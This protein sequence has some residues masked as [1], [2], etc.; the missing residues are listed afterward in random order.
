MS[1]RKQSRIESDDSSSSNSAQITSGTSLVSSVAS[2]PQF[3]PDREDLYQPGNTKSAIWRNFKAHK[4][5]SGY[6]VC[7]ICLEQGKAVWISRPMR[8]NSGMLSHMN[9]THGKE[10]TTVSDSKQRAQLS[11]S[12]MLPREQCLFESSERGITAL[13]RHGNHAT[14]LGRFSFISFFLFSNQ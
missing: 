2:K 9:R 13:C 12:K 4:K 8:T 14:Q 10:G 7:M 6:V 11:I 5:I 3:I 1:K